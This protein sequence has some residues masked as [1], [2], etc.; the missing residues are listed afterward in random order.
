MIG[1][2][3]DHEEEIARDALLAALTRDP[4]LTEAHAVLLVGH[5]DQPDRRIASGVGLSIPDGPLRQSALAALRGGT[6]SVG[7]SFAPGALDVIEIEIASVRRNNAG[8]HEMI[9][10]SRRFPSIY[11]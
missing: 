9:A 4:G 8:T 10:A 1:M 7:W 5:G 2:N 11:S 6:E 3:L